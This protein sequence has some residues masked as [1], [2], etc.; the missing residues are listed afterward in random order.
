MK[1]FFFYF[2]LLLSSYNLHGQKFNTILY[3]HAK[4]VPDSLEQDIVDLVLYLK[5]PTKNNQELVEIFFYWISINISYDVECYTTKKYGS[6]S[7]YNVLESKKSVC[8]GY[9]NLFFELCYNADIECEIING[10]A[11]GYGYC[12]GKIK[13]ENHAW[14]AVKID[15]QWKLLDVT[16]G[17]GYGKEENGKLKYIPHLD[18]KYLFPDP[19]DFILDHLPSDSKFQ[20]L[21]DKISEEK[22]FSKEFEL[23]RL[24]KKLTTE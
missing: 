7:A 6:Q 16:W 1:T 17:S 21:D 18:L 8:A 24:N 3:E 15:S 13:E 20:L 2:T 5:I 12:G 4:L 23:I 9:A 11:K 10:K 14:N 19:N 22:Y